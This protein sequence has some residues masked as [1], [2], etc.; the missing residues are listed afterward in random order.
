LGDVKDKDIKSRLV[1][2]LKSL[3][4]FVFDRR[5]LDSSVVEAI[6][7]S[8]GV[9]SLLSKVVIG[10][11]VIYYVDTSR[12]K[13]RCLYEK[14]SMEDIIAREACLREC[15]IFMEREIV[16]IITEALQHPT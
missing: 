11:L 12:F 9:S 6:L 8:Y 10:D 13:R 1:R 15:L 3:G 2:S 16:R 14:C 7:S 4:A 5:L